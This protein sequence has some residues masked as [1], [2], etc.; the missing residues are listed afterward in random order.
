M[1][2]EYML[3]FHNMMITQWFMYFNFR[4]KLKILNE[5]TFC[6]ALVRLS[7]VFAIIFTAIIFLFS[8]LVI[9]KHLAKPPL[10]SCLPLVYFFV[11]I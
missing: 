1:I 7:D 5:Y 11:L 8:R 4:D 3:E 2:L 6:L 10:P 9:S